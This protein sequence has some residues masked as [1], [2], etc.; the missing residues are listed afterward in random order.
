[1]TIST[2]IN[3]VSEEEIS[4]SSFYSI[5][6]FI[7]SGRNS[8]EKR[9]SCCNENKASGKDFKISIDEHHELC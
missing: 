5:L 6:S 4:H 2:G 3:D 8:S 1:M 7:G 9:S